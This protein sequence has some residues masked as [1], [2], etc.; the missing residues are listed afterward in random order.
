MRTHFYEILKNN[1]QHFF[2]IKRKKGRILFFD[3]GIAP[4]CPAVITPL[5][6]TINRRFK[7][8]LRGVLRYG[9]VGI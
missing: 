1:Y 5:S 8:F 2:K 7:V 9:M 3:R 4:K 6:G